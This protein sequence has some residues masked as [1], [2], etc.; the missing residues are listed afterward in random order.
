M[1]YDPNPNY[2][3]I[4]SQPETS[5]VNMPHRIDQALAHPWLNGK[6]A[7]DTPLPDIQ[8]EVENRLSWR[9]NDTHFLLPVTI[10]ILILPE[11]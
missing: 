11:A 1:L 10:P 8:A 7:P 5:Q 3:A 6:D 4:M 2:G 9:R